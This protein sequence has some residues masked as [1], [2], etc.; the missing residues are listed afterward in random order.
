MQDGAEAII[1]N[2]FIGNEEDS[3]DELSIIKP[4]QQEDG[5]I[6]VDS[7]AVEQVHQTFEYRAPDSAVLM[8]NYDHQIEKQEDSANQNDI[9]LNNQQQQQPVPTTA[10][11]V[12][13]TNEAWPNQNQVT[14]AFN[15]CLKVRRRPSAPII[16]NYK[17]MFSTQDE[18]EGLKVE[19]ADGREAPRQNLQLQDHI[20]QSNQAITTVI[21][22]IRG[23][24]EKVDT[25]IER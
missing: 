15:R 20:G 7:A 18:I 4:W 24:C 6:R 11:A 5:Q 16:G 17:E 23:T 22:A 2:E 1:L 8:A 9:N 14:R 3:N 12:A 19:Q 25:I 21:E 10:P 13:T